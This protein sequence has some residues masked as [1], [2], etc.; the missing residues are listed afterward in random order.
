MDSSE[1]DGIAIVFIELNSKGA[2]N[3]VKS[4]G[5]DMNKRWNGFACGL[6]FK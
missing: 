6:V 1:M 2:V 3:V 5:N 4:F